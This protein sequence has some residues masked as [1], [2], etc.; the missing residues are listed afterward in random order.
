MVENPSTCVIATALTDTPESAAISVAI[1]VIIA[2]TLGIVATAPVKVD[3][4]AS[5]I[6]F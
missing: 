1:G 4:S 2:G 3:A 5:A 6:K